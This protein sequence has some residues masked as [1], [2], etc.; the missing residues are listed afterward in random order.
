MNNDIHDSHIQCSH[1]W[2]KSTCQL[3]LWGLRQLGA[4]WGAEANDCNMVP[5]LIVTSSDMH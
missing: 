1:A 3:L 2:P 4:S 5:L